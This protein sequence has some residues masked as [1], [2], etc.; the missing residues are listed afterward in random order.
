MTHTDWHPSAHVLAELAEDALIGDEHSD[1][2]AHV[3]ACGAC[4]EVLAQLTEV[5]RMLR[6]APAELPVPTDVSTRLEEALAEVDGGAEKD[7]SATVTALADRPVAWFRRRLPQALAAAAAV[8]VLGVVGYAALIDD[9]SPVDVAADDAAGQNDAEEPV[10]ADGDMDE[11]SPEGA[12]ARQ[13]DV[14]TNEEQEE[15]SANVMADEAA[16][17]AVLDVWE[18]ETEVAPG[19]GRELAEELGLELVGSTQVDEEIVVVLEDDGTL[20]GWTVSS[21]TAVDAVGPLTSGI[22]VD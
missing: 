16:E 11:A 5:T 17:S 2:Q 13:E 18:R 19:C 15:S 1:V 10:T 14:T 8:A 3:R 9:E 4:Q 20:N 7:H 22:A 12:E 21:C 6:S